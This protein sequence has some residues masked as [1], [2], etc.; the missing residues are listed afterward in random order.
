M[1]E[2]EMDWEET[3]SVPNEIHPQGARSKGVNRES[4]ARK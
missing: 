3:S 4:E 2:Y 1:N